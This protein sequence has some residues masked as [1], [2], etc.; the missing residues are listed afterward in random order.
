[1]N[2]EMPTMPPTI[3]YLLRR[4]GWPLGLLIVSFAGISVGLP[5]VSIPVSAVWVAW[6]L[7]REQPV[8][9]FRQKLPRLAALVPL[10]VAPPW[11]FISMSRTAWDDGVALFVLV[12]FIAPW[13]AIPFVA[14]L[15]AMGVI[16]FQHR[17]GA[18]NP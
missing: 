1:M 6:L 16:V 14:G 9:N 4:Y 5:F 10:I 7:A 18:A 13:L 15:I 17:S 8:Q 2:S 12:A 3:Q 11:L